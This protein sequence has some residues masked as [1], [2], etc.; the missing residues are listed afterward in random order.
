MFMYETSSAFMLQMQKHPIFNTGAN[1]RIN[2][3][4]ISTLSCVVT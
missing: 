2:F 1:I 4:K 3:D